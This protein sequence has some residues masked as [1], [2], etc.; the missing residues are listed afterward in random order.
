MKVNRTRT[1]RSAA[2]FITDLFALQESLQQIRIANNHSPTA[3]L[4]HIREPAGRI[5]CECGQWR[6]ELRFQQR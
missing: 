3:I 2:L 5:N 4:A 1:N 6:D